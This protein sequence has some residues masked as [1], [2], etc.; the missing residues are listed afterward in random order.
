[1]TLCGIGDG[2]SEVSRAFANRGIGYTGCAPRNSVHAESK[3]TIVEISI[4]P[5]VAR[6]ERGTGLKKRCPIR[7]YLTRY[8]LPEFGAFHLYLASN[9][10]F[11]TFQPYMHASIHHVAWIDRLVVAGQVKAAVKRVVKRRRIESGL[12]RAA[13]RSA[14]RN[15]IW[16]V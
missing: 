8:L 4:K 16:N 15:R 14:Y 7:H 10:D 12:G 9:I 11:C 13:L 5:G 3:Q 2:S 1:M 6:R